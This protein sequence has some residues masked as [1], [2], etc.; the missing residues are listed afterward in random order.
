MKILLLGEYSNVHNTLALG[1]RALGHQVVV[2]SNG[3]FWKDYPRDIDVARMPGKLGGIMLMAKLYALL[4]K[5]RG[6]DVVQLINPIFFELKAERLFWFYRY[7]RQHNKRVFLG[8][9]GMDYYWVHACT[10][11]KPLRYSD[12]NIGNHVRTDTEA[13]KY[14][15]DWL[16]TTKEQLN[17]LIAQ[18][19]DGIIAGLYEYWACYS[20]VYADKTCFIPFP[21]KMP[22]S[23]NTERAQKSKVVIFIG[24]NRERSVYKGTDIMLQAA[25]DVQHKYPQRMKLNIAESVPFAEYSQ[26]MEGSDA[27]LDQLYA[28]TPSMNPLLAM[29]K[30][31]ICIGGGE[32]ENYEIINE[33]ELCPIINVEPTY[34]SVYHELEQL[35]LNPN[36]IPELKR[37][38]VA[39]VKKHHDYLK[40]AQQ[41]LDFWTK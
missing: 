34:E 7:L 8:A 5:L 14:Q 31:I 4:P 17:K 25:K 35:V 24:I 12:F 27:I 23:Y 32:P 30:G 6:Y 40:V 19:C 29:S 26:L 37:Q 16:G 39:Y 38:S 3:D 18:D 1:L 2:I 10:Y 13:V 36:R 33:T 22:E 21:I 41:Y 20:P 11:E 28:Y 15:R 9:F